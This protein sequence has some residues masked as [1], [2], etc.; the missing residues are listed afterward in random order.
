MSEHCDDC[1]NL[2]HSS[3]KGWLCSC[4]TFKNISSQF[5]V[6][7]SFYKVDKVSRTPVQLKTDANGDPLKCAA[8]IRREGRAG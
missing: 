5:R 6:N 7:R 4:T 2:C 1:G 3:K 8:C